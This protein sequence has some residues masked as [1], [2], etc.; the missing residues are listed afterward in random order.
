MVLG[1]Y[2]RAIG[3][4]KSCQDTKTALSQLLD[5][6]FPKEKVSVIA[7]DSESQERLSRA[8][9]VNDP[10][11][12]QAQKSVASG[13]V[14]G[15]TVGGLGNLLVG[16][17]TVVIPGMGS[18]LTIGSMGK[19]LSASVADAGNEATSD[20]LVRAFTAVGIPEDRARVYSDRIS[21]GDY[22]VIVEGTQ[23]EITKAESLLS[24]R[25]IQEWG[26]YEAPDDST[27]MATEHR[28]SPV[29][30]FSTSKEVDSHNIEV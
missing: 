1:Q 10:V 28:V 17:G 19:T 24:E 30:S 22:V 14:A 23:E 3:A 5:F 15:T 6:G 2:I 20:S 13:T 11:A 12:T 21:Q 8:N 26:V 27:N 7:K 25:G 9:N 29:S 4:F 16:L 18:L